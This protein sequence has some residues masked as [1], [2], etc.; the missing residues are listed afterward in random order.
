METVQQ[1][2]Y[3][4]DGGDAAKC[5]KIAISKGN[6]FDAYRAVEM[7]PIYSYGEAKTD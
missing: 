7:A 1:G 2:Q 6:G 5:P 4:D 3:V